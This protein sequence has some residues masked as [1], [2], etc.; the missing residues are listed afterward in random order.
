MQLSYLDQRF[1]LTRANE[2]CATL[3]KAERRVQIVKRKKI[4][5]PFQEGASFRTNAGAID[6][7]LYF[8]GLTTALTALNQAGEEVLRLTVGTA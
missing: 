3:S 4:G 5:K 7:P 6:A 1:E 8:N 2:R